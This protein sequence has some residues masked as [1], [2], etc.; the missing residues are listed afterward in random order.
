MQSAETVLDVLRE[1]GGRGL[2][3][4]ELYRQLFNPH[5]YL[6][7][8]G[9]LYS[10]H[11]A[12]TPGADGETVD[13]MSLARIGRV[14]DAL[15]HERYRFQPVKRVYIPKKSGKLRPLGLP[16][17][18]DKLVGEVIRLLL[19]AY[20]EPRFSGR[21]HGFRPG[22]GCHTALSEVAAKWTGTAWFIEGDISDCFGSLDHSV[23]LSILA[24][25]IHDNRFLRLIRQMLQ[26]GYLEDWEW[27]ATLSGC[28]QGGVVSP[29]LSNIYLDRLDKFAETVLIPEYTRGGF[30][31]D[32]PEYGRVRMAAGRAH[33]RG[34]RQ[35]ASALR[36]RLRGL[37]SGDPRDPGFRR[38]HYTRYA[39]DHLLGF[40]GPRAEAEQI[41]D[42]LA[43]FLRDDLKLELSPE[44]TLITHARTG[45]ARFLGYEI[46]TQHSRCRRKV[47]GVIGLRVPGQVIKAK[48]APYS[49]LGKP[50]RRTELINCDDLTIIST[51]GAEYRG[52][53]QYYLLAGDVWRLKRLRWAA[54]TSMLKTLA[55]K[56][57]SSV[58]KMA[59]KYKAT[60]VTPHGPRTCFQ[61]TV[62]RAGKKPLVARFGG[63]PL[64]R[65]KK[66]VIE[67]RLPAP[68]ASRKELITRL[69]AGWCELCE[70]RGQVEVH[71]IRKLADLAGNR[72][73]QPEWAQLMARRRRK[74]LVV[75]PDCHQRV[76]TTAARRD[77]HALVTGEPDD[78]KR[79]RPVRAGG[80]RK[81]TRPAGTSPAAYRYP[82]P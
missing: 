8:Y 10:N 70:Q 7:A 66:A 37:P 62:E 23:M 74:T 80:R 24:E 21:S 76:H 6:L 50:E 61:A 11:G 3:C 51:Y 57:E 35:T 29:V 78:R 65:Q 15:R 19:E 60:I 59:R 22:R 58:T 71:Q 36:K 13:G 42:R 72:L 63:I 81:R 48:C 16:S 12:M 49:K 46:T 14:I 41:K 69:R 9:R 73:P 79:S 5:L 77:P 27:N 64:K 56:H 39:D 54:E 44:K 55:A 33:R 68:P 18:S 25:N 1:R 28:P 52:L 17:W 53:V 26:A 2:P 4:E 43:A 31:K 75:C 45:A 34:D 47:N 30:R 32:N 20:Y 40:A 67:D 82:A 38:L